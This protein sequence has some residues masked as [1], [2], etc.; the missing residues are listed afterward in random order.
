MRRIYTLNE[1]Q[2]A[3]ERTMPSMMD[4]EGVLTNLSLGVTGEAGELGNMIKKA[5]FHGHLLDNDK[6]LEELGDI[7][8]YVATMAQAFDEDLST[9]AEGNIAKLK[10]RYPDGFS[11]KA[12]R[13]RGKTPLV[14]REEDERDKQKL[15]ENMRD[16]DCWKVGDGAAVPLWPYCCLDCAGVFYI[17]DTHHDPQQCPICG[18]F[19]IADKGVE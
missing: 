2:K 8:W 14:F 7:L 6:V 4:Q 13:N 19:T 18:G 1:Y 10:E 5:V 16:E 12:S 17:P 3:A 15:R 11:Q 9:V